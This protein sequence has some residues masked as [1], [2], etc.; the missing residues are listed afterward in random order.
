MVSV[1]VLSLLSAISLAHMTPVRHHLVETEQQHYLV[2]I[3]PGQ[4][5]EATESPHADRC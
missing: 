4:E 3:G 5:D 2:E 1:K